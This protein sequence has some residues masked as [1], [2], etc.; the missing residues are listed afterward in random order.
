M[1]P[2]QRKRSAL[3][4]VRHLF[5]P[6][7]KP[8]RRQP[9]LVEALEDRTVLDMQGFTIGPMY[10]YGDFFQDTEHN[11]WAT[12]EVKLGFAPQPNESFEELAV[13]SANS[14]DGKVWFSP[15]NPN[16]EF[17]VT[18]CE[19]ISLVSL[20]NLTL[21]D[22]EGSFIFNANALASNG[23]N[24][25]SDAKPFT[26]DAGKFT[27]DKIRFVAPTNE[28]DKGEIWMQG[29]LTQSPLDQLTFTVAGTNFLKLTKDGIVLT[30][31]SPAI[32]GGLSIAGLGFT[33]DDLS[34]N[35]ANGTFTLTGSAKINLTENESV[36]VTFAS[37]GLQVSGGQILS[38]PLVLNSNL[39][40][41]GVTFAT[42]NLRMDYNTGTFSLTGQVSATIGE[43]SL[44]VTFGGGG[45]AGLKIVNGELTNLDMSFQGKFN[46]L[47]L[48]IEAGTKQNPITITYTKATNSTPSLFTLS[49]QISVPE[50]WHASV[51]LG[52]QGHPGL[53]VQD[54]DFQLENVKFEL[55]GVTLGAFTIEEL[56]VAFTPHTFAVTLDLWFPAGWKVDGY[57][58]FENGKLNAVKL[59]LQG[60]EGIEIGDTGITITG[61]QGGLQ[62]LQ[63]PADIIVTGGLT[64]NWLSNEFVTVEGDFTIDRDELVLHGDVTFLNGMG[65]G[66]VRLVLDWGEQD[67]SA[68]VKVDWLDGTFKF[69]AIMDIHDGDSV[70]VK[71]KADVDVPDDIPFIGGQT[72]AEIDF[73][74]EWHKDW[75]DSENF[76]AAWVDLD[77]WLF[78]IDV[79]V[80]VDFTGHAK[81]IGSNDIHHIESPPPD[82]QPQLYHYRI[83][84]NVDQNVTQGTLHVQWPEIAG[85]QSIAIVLP[86]GTTI[87]QSQFADPSH[88]LT[89]LAPLTSRQSYGLGMAGSSTDPYVPLQEGT[90]QIVLTSNYKFSSAPTLTAAFGTAPPTV[91]T[92]TVPPQPSSLKVP[93]TLTGK[94]VTSLG[95]NARAT[96]YFDSDTSGHNGT[97]IPGAT[98]L[99]VTVDDQG[100]WT[101]QATWDMDGLLPLP[102]YV[103]ASINDGVSGTVH[104]GYSIPITPN[105]TLSGTVTTYTQHE[106]ESGLT[107]FVDV[108]NNN[109]F[110]PGTDPYTSTGDA[111]FYSFDSSV[112]P[113]NKPFNVGL[114]IT[115]GY[116]MHGGSPSIVPA[117][118]DGTNQLSISFVVDEFAAIHGKVTANFDAGNQPLVGWTVYRDANNNGVLDDGEVTTLTAA[119]GSFVFRNLPLNTTQVVR[120][121]VPTGYYQTSPT[122]SYT[123]TVS[124]DQFEVYVGK[125]FTALPFSTVSGTISGYALQNGSLSPTATPQSGVPVNLLRIAAINPGGAAAGNYLADPGPTSGAASTAYNYDRTINTSD[126]T[127]PAPEVVYQSNR[128]GQTFEYA[129]TGLTP[130]ATHTVRLHFAELYWTEPGKRLFNV[131]I[132]GQTVLSN[133]DIF[134]K[135]GGEFIAVVES[136]TAT[137]DANGTIT[138][139]FTAVT[140]NA[141]INGI[142]VSELVASTTT[143]A[144]G[145]YSFSELKAGT[146]TVSEVVPNGWREVAPFTSDLQLRT[147]SGAD[148]LH[149]PQLA[150]NPSPDTVGVA[151][152]DGDGKLDVAVLDAV[153][154]ETNNQSYVW[155]Y[156][157][158][159]WDSPVRLG[160]AFGTN[161]HKM[162]IGD[163]WSTG[164]PNIAVFGLTEQ[165][166]HARVD[167]LPNVA[168][169][170]TN[171]FGPMIWGMWQLQDYDRGNV[172]D[173]TLLPDS[174]VIPG[175]QLAVFYFNKQGQPTIAT[176]WRDNSGVHYSYPQLSNAASPQQMLAADVNDDG[177]SDLVVSDQFRSPYVLFGSATGLSQ[178]IFIQELPEALHVM[179]ADINGDG[180][181]DLGVFDTNGL[182]HYATQN[183]AGNFTAITPGIGVQGHT[184]GSAFFRDINGDLLPDLIWVVEGVG[185]KALHVVTNS[186]ED[187]NWFVPKQQT[188]WELVPGAAGSLQM[189]AGDLDHDGLAELVISDNTAGLVEIIRNQSVTN[190]TSITV[191]VDGNTS[192]GNNFVNAQIG[193]IGGRVFDDTNRDGQETSAESG[194]QGVTVFVD[195]N[196]NGRLDR[197][198]PRSV[199]G[200]DGHYA[201]D[202]LPAGTYQIR[203]VPEIGRKLTLPQTQV[204]EVT[205]GPNLPP[206]MDKHFGSMT[207]NN[208]TLKIPASDETWRLY[209]NGDR[210]DIQESQKGVVASYQLDNIDSLTVLGTSQKAE[211]LILDLATGGSFTIPGGITFQ[212]GHGKGDRLRVLLSGGNDQVSV[213]GMTAVMN[214]KLTIEWDEV[215]CLTVSGGDGDDWLGIKGIPLQKGQIVLDGGPGNDIYA[216]AA[217]RSTVRVQDEAGCDTLDFGAAAAGVQV[218]LNQTS[219]RPQ[220]IDRLK[221]QL[222]LQGDIEN[223]IGSAFD[224]R[225]TGGRGRNLLIGGAGGDVLRGEGADDILVGGTTA[226]D[227][228][229][230]SLRALAA[231]WNSLRS[232]D[233]RV[234]NLIDGTAT[235]ERLNGDIF[236]NGMTLFDDGMR[237]I[238]F[239]GAGFDW[240]LGF[241]G[242]TRKDHQ[243]DERSGW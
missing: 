46:L 126:V 116:Q 92:P 229:E 45:T 193:Q 225:L 163:F 33:I 52:S 213:S 103:Y 100:N 212:G 240:F 206:Q 72:L 59:G 186:G 17:T 65:K 142:E 2:V 189:A 122:D 192:T 165:K 75:S 220:A 35:Y 121:D 79:G 187:G 134:A 148:I 95:S 27:L 226:Y 144:E 120:L 74:L 161:Y 25:T 26:V 204:Y 51:I 201:F 180:L 53:V 101:V 238:L 81:M 157:N 155:I 104:S 239:G 106:P 88:N 36:Q 217:R 172:G 48:E 61:F 138:L 63:H 209:R 123:V 24:I 41:S 167:V 98:N 170:R 23:V 15:D 216:L 34:A 114:V 20:P 22:T 222:L 91:D 197:R 16:P 153:V 215:E 66:D 6:R 58:E 56:L 12:G 99:P 139:S 169:S 185:T 135:A 112:L 223:A 87:D 124:N 86:D 69:D 207:S 173:F 136:F 175:D 188:V 164:R 203:I 39:S 70:Y 145:N 18:D 84:F 119:D 127:N 236:L 125:N 80:K 132:N 210:L 147:P 44:T 29:S 177:Y 184:V 131:A 47:D 130:N 11:W 128:Y 146:Y 243:P 224:D 232:Y 171:N 152:F 111:G 219:S 158:G 129:I 228:V 168:N 78:S 214:D 190:P 179:A 67:Y 37:P 150:G 21:W 205:V 183:Q 156:Y 89:L 149:L 108:N 202:G 64:A 191:T 141:Q 182:F 83:P 82:T 102:Y 97:P 9:L 208:L 77:F 178:Q 57:V 40:F 38:F 198:E 159:A 105:P 113:V 235:S 4:W 218:E 118:Y 230:A 54:G 117:S 154:N 195:R 60:N 199:T 28:E 231:E 42:K 13:F 227:G 49:G 234:Q 237:D 30:G 166:Y 151:D 181:T 94:V 107:V 93:V 5:T 133:Y 242:D 110:D 162:V 174:K 221:N 96:L 71:A 233:E 85:N 31:V 109:Q 14:S 241:P 32:S 140:D 211:R 115:E 43:Q 176:L 19:L 8:Y 10:L 90:Y 73:V 194:R 55:Q 160:L 1:N 7:L 50:L 200:P 143:D 137:A 76:V 196:R 68:T 62:N 3:S